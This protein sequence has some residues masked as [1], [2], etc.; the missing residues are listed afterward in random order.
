[1][2]V[3]CRRVAGYDNRIYINRLKDEIVLNN[4]FDRSD[5]ID[6]KFAVSH[7]LALSCKLSVRVLY[8]WI[9]TWRLTP[10]EV[11]ESEIEKTIQETKHLPEQLAEDGSRDTR[12]PLN[13]VNRG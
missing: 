6:A 8:Q 2:R 12:R 3:S 13:H 10:V 9:H 5:D 7:G 1:M 4:N 11:F